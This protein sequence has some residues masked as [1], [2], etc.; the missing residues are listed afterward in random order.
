MTSIRFLGN[1]CTEI[2]GEQD[3]I[4]ID[5]VF[6]LT[7]T[8]GI[9]SIFLT[10]HHPDHMNVDIISE[11]QEKDVKN[12][13]E[14]PIFGPDSIQEEFSIDLTLIEPG[15]VVNINNGFVEIFENDCWK[16]PGCVAYLIVI[17]N[18]RILHTA[19][20][21][22]FS[23]NLKEIKDSIDVCFIACF[24]RNFNDYLSFLQTLS[25]KVTIP[26][27]FNYEKEEE[28]KKLTEFLNDNGINSKFLSIGLEYK[29]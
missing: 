13:A 20:S 10:H 5:P 22:S 7:P 23:Q 24:E 1:A 17:D 25:P 16:A 18:K 21:A 11:I 4:I 12:G 19:D 15:S 3:H 6:L 28:G 29:L 27:H 14:I 8:K 26:Y 2:I 9:D